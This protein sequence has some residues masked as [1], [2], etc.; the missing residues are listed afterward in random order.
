MKIW[1]LMEGVKPLNAHHSEQSAL[2]WLERLGYELM[3]KP[4]WQM[5]IKEGQ[6]ITLHEASYYPA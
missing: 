1:I 5:W 6:L 2:D 4:E 3:G